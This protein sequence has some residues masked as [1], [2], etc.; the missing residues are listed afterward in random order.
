MTNRIR[1]RDARP[2]A[3]WG[4]VIGA[5]TSL[6]GSAISA[7]QQERA[8]REQKRQQEL[9]DA[10]NLAANMTQVMNLNE[11]AQR[12]YEDQFRTNFR[13]GGRPK[14]G[15]GWLGKGL[16]N[17]LPAI[18]QAA[19]SI[20]DGFLI[21]SN[22]TNVNSTTSDNT[23]KTDTSDTSEKLAYGG[24]TRPTAGAVVQRGG[25]AQP[26][27]NNTFLLRGMSH[28]DTNSKGQSGIYLN[29]NGRDVE[30]EGGEILHKNGN[31]FEI[32]SDRI[33]YDG[34][35]YA[36]HVLSGENPNYI[37]D[38]QEQSKRRRL[39]TGGY[40]S[41][42]REIAAFGWPDDIWSSLVTRGRRF[43]GADRNNSAYNSALSQAQELINSNTTNVNGSPFN[44]YT[45]TAE[46]LVEYNPITNSYSVRNP[47][48]STG[49]A[50]S[51]AFRVNPAKIARGVQQT[52]RIA[53]SVRNSMRG[54]QAA[55]AARTTARATEQANR[56]AAEAEKARRAQAALRSIGATV[57][58]TSTAGR[59]AY[60][61]ARAGSSSA[62][63]LIDLRRLY[64][65]NPGLPP[66]GGVPEGS[67]N[68]RTGIN[69]GI[70]GRKVLPYVVGIGGA[71][72]LVGGTAYLANRGYNRTYPSTTPRTQLGYNVANPSVLDTT[73][74]DS[75]F[76]APIDSIVRDSAF[77]PVD[78]INVNG[79]QINTTLPNDTMVANLANP[80]VATRVNTEAD[81]L[82][83]AE[84][85]NGVAPV[86]PRR[87]ARVPTNSTSTA[88]NSGTTVNR[89]A[90]SSG[91]MT[92]EER[93]RILRQGFG[94]YT[95]NY[96]NYDFLRGQADTDYADRVRQDMQNR[97]AA[98]MTGLTYNPETGNLE[99]APTTTVEQTLPSNRLGMS[100][101]TG[102]FINAGIGILGSVL[103][104][105]IMQRSLRNMSK[106]APSAP[107]P[108]QAGKLVTTFNINP[109]LAEIERQRQ[110][111]FR[112]INQNTASS[113]AAIQRQQAVNTATTDAENK[114]WAQ[115]FN[116]E[117]EML[118]RD[119]LNRQQVANMNTQAYNRWRERL[120]DYNRGLG[121]A[122]ASS[123]VA[124]I[125]GIGDSLSGLIESGMNNYNRDLD[126][127]AL[128]A[129]SEQG[130]VER[131]INFGYPLD[132]QTYAS[133]AINSKNE[134][135][136]RLAYS[137]LTKRNQRRLR[138][139][140]LYVS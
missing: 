106:Y 17:S 51:G 48:L 49:I 45:G 71:G 65:G 26:I 131:L 14:C 81:P 107:T 125:Q 53:T 50:P 96:D 2:K 132:Q 126:R 9:A 3:F 89:P 6:V 85:Q 41:P 91:T 83:I 99:A 104:N 103:S 98:D 62:R 82:T 68:F 115:K 117:A 76:I 138:N 16:L 116:T 12:A 88:T 128:A 56:A 30:A 113:A 108:Y 111:N 37:F 67:L 23:Y 58:N 32:I 8:A 29:L 69:L 46:D 90:Q 118:N 74:V 101:T 33:G 1:L 13:L 4:A 136:R 39:R 97:V 94:P 66:L 42:V 112:A 61:G 102:D 10:R 34:Q 134:D 18:G 22:N 15:L 80:N 93:D 110:Q 123:N 95:T 72:A 73:R 121:Q 38:M 44:L 64:T 55:N 43:I 5:A 25:V 21:N 109:Q 28:D 24:K 100:P 130:T 114:L 140:G 52:A 79:Q 7:R 78:S 59:N 127:R 40:S 75:S 47:Y 36:D 87:P 105:S 31:Q 86:S 70:N 137:K 139:G 92:A 20:V 124:M 35:S 122:R 57:D 27:G 11:N 133:I 63:D 120:D 84:R 54:Q 135:A 60:A 77:V 119:T 129:A 19:G